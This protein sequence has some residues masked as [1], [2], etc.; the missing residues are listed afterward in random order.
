MMSYIL[1][2][3]RVTMQHNSTPSNQISEA[4]H[5]ASLKLIPDALLEIMDSD[6]NHA[7]RKTNREALA[8][9]VSTY[10]D[11][12][13]GNDQDTITT[14]HS[15]LLEQ[16]TSL[17]PKQGLA[18]SIM[19]NNYF[20]WLHENPEP[21]KRAEKFVAQIRDNIVNPQG[22]SRSNAYSGRG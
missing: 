11:A 20:T 2:L 19:A 13:G 8:T 6:L 15:A 3:S 7:S 18:P 22:A 9:A 5:H 21:E 10:A 16:V 12:L 1:N 14:A 4:Q 17:C